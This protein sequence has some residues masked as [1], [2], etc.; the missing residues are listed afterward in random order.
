MNYESSYTPK[1]TLE[2][3]EGSI[4]CR[5]KGRN[6]IAIMR[7]IELRAENWNACNKC[8]FQ[9]KEWPDKYMPKEKEE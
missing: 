7:C 6:H 8:P 9:K 2:E 3:P 4:P 1:R 5:R